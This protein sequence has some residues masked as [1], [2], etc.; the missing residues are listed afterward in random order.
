MEIEDE[1]NV[2][3]QP[4][5]SIAEAPRSIPSSDDQPP[6]SNASSDDS[7]DDS[8]PTIIADS[9]DQLQ[10][11]PTTHQPFNQPRFNIPGTSNITFSTVTTSS[12]NTTKRPLSYSEAAQPQ[13]RPR[14]TSQD[15]P[16]MTTKHI[17]IT[18][19]TQILRRL[20]Y[21]TTPND[22]ITALTDQF[23]LTQP[24]QTI[25]SVIHVSPYEIAPP[26]SP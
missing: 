18:K 24:Q 3:H 8:P 13:K 15:Q 16:T 25:H 26:C 2:L 19:R 7:S 11:L 4:P 23:H 5:R 21:G 1:L 14:T 17:Q 9:N 20:P 10:Q 12:T 22:V 6:R